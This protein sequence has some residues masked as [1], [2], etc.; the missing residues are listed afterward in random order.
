MLLNEW[1][2]DVCEERLKMS[3]NKGFDSK[4]LYFRSTLVTALA[5]YI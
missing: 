1:D 2:H 4:L 3:I 5:S